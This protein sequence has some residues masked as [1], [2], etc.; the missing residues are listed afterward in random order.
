MNNADGGELKH[1]RAKTASTMNKSLPFYFETSGEKILDVNVD[2]S[3][4]CRRMAPKILEK[5][6]IQILQLTESICGDSVLFYPLA[7]VYA[8]ENAAKIKTSEKAEYIRT[9]FAE[10]ERASSNLSWAGNLASNL[11][12]DS[13]MYLAFN[14]RE[15]LLGLNEGITGSRILKDFV[16]IGG[17]KKDLTKEDLNK[18]K[19]TLNVIK[20]DMEKL[21]RRFLRNRSFKSKTR[22]IGILNHE[23]ALKLCAVGPT[24]RASGVKKDVRVDCP[25]SI[26][27]DLD[28]GFTLPD[29]SSSQ[30][31]GD[32]YDRTL[33]KILEIKQS[34]KLI[35][36]AIKKIPSEKA[37]AE[38]D[39]ELLS[40]IKK[41]RGQGLGRCESPAG[42]IIHF[43]KFD[44]EKTTL[45]AWDFRSATF[46]NIL[47][48]VSMLKGAQIQDAPIILHS[49]DPDISLI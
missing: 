40:K 26:Y 22:G 9:I 12:F 47:P 20:T 41:I 35:E 29:L 2:L 31:V 23:D 15:N 37:T 28:V 45:S 30:M 44:G 19:E 49:I 21:E 32:V 17:V 6:P 42:E 24:A 43:V 8:V 11:A 38:N 16:R 46:N 3:Y 5:N 14:I 4:F 34:I 13:A 33:V 27:A 18:I 48:L 1:R 39:D 7:F 10:I 36:E 25:Y